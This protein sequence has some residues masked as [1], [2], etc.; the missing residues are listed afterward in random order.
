[1][2]RI[3]PVIAVVLAALPASAHARA[4]DLWTTV[5]TC[6]TAARPGSMGV[7]GRM[8]GDGT[9]AKM[10]MRFAA[11][12]MDS[13][14]RWEYVDG[15]GHSGW[16]YAGS[17]R[18]TYEEAGFTFTFD[19]PKAGDRFVFRGVT[20]FQ[21]RLRKRVHGKL[22]TVIVDHDRLVTEAGHP[23]STADPAGYSAASCEIDGPA[24]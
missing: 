16:I 23:T 24:G 19:P 2:R 1:M 8:P 10:Y 21:W 7:R 22:R 4:S 6:N 15:D 11:Q 13:A 18:F 17:S 14:G 5:N 3:A 20:D 9:R 12:F